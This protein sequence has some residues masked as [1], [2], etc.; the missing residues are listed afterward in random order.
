MYV[1]IQ[2]PKGRKVNMK[3][4]EYKLVDFRKSFFPKFRETEMK[5]LLEVIKQ[6]AEE[7]WRFVQIFGESTDI[8]GIIGSARALLIFERE[9]Q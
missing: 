6:H 4:Y 2:H 5:T 8:G 7:G 3:K 9:I 1:N